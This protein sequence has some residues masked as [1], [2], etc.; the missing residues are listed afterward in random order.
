MQPQPACSK[1]PTAMPYECDRCGACCVH[2][3]IEIDQLDIAREPRLRVLQPFKLPFDGQPPPIDPDDEDDEARDDRVCGPLVPG[4]EAGA[5]LACG[6][7]MP[8]PMLGPDKLCTIYP[9][10]PNVCVAFRAGSLQC[11]SARQA[12]GLGE[13][14]PVA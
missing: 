13:L 2:P 3:I 12:A 1:E 4:F 8:C 7:N 14:Q 10:R 9:T 6:P 5:M 11:Q